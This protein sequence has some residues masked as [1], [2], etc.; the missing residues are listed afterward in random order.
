MKVFMV[1]LKFL[2]IL[3]KF[4]FPVAIS[5]SSPTTIL[6]LIFFN[7]SFVI[8]SLPPPTLKLRI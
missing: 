3:F 8:S 5:I 7:F 6:K 2:H 4:H 1:N